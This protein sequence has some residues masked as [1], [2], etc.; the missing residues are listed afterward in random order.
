[1]K[2]YSPF[3]DYYDGLCKSYSDDDLVYIRKSSEIYEEK[4]TR[5]QVKEVTELSKLYN[6]TNDQ[7]NAK[8]DLRNYRREGN[9]FFICGKVYPIVEFSY[10]NFNKPLEKTSYGKNLLGCELTYEGEYRKDY[11]LIFPPYED[12]LKLN[13]KY[14]C[15]ILRFAYKN[16]ELKIE[17]NPTLKKYDFQKYL[18]PFDIYQALSYYLG[19]ILVYRE[20]MPT[21]TNTQKIQMH[22][23]D[24]KKSFRG[25]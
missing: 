6:S 3:Q 11:T 16:K 23:F 17:F 8:Y 4:Q 14:W 21:P 12:T 5:R 15:P 25:K 10:Y 9:F 19:N 13:E 2:I 1:M 7:F 22:G 18:Q 24:V 20:I